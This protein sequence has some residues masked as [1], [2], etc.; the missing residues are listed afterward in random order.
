[1]PWFTSL[2]FQP[3]ACFLHWLHYIIQGISAA[4]AHIT[5]KHQILSILSMQQ[6]VNEARSDIFKY[7]LCCTGKRNFFPH[8]HCKPVIKFLYYRA[9]EIK[10]L[11][12]GVKNMVL[13][14]LTS[15]SHAHKIGSRSGSFQN[16]RWAPLS[17]LYG[18]PSVPSPGKS[19]KIKKG[20]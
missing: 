11:W 19:K 6:L 17:F 20:Y 1:M 12:Q 14:P 15:L 7:K 2:T 8:C 9:A 4:I 13:V 10:T 18:S 16:F 3:Y 5:R